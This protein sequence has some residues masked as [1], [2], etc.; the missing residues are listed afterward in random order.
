MGSEKGFARLVFWGGVILFTRSSLETKFTPIIDRSP[1]RKRSLSTTLL[2]PA[3][4][5]QC[6]V[7]A[8]LPSPSNTR[9]GQHLQEREENFGRRPSRCC[10]CHRNNSACQVPLKPAKRRE[11]HRE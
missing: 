3:Q 1:K 8:S 9:D 5:A 4:L 10:C 11:N 7:G 2:R 6:T